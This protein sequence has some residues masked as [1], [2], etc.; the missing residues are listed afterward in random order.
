[1]ALTFTPWLDGGFR[2]AVTLAIEL[3]AALVTAFVTG[4]VRQRTES[5]PH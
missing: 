4:G 5:T 3:Y 2:V 1:M